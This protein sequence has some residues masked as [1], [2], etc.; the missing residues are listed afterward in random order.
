MDSL[1]KCIMATSFFLVA[2]LWGCA[3]HKMALSTSQT[4]AAKSSLILLEDETPVTKSKR[5]FDENEFQFEV[6]TR[7]DVNHRVL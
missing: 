6:Y 1:K 5:D 7:V 3:S 2:L 4:G